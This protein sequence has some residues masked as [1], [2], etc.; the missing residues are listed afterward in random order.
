[1]YKVVK[2]YIRTAFIY[3]Y[4]ILFEESEANSF[5][6][7]SKS[8]QQKTSEKSSRANS[9][10]SFGTR[11]ERI[12]RYFSAHTQYTSTL[13][14]LS[15]TKDTTSTFNFLRSRRNSA[16]T[17]ASISSLASSF[18]SINYA[19]VRQIGLFHHHRRSSLTPASAAQND[20]LE[21]LK[22]VLAVVN[23]SS[24]PKLA[25]SNFSQGD[26]NIVNNILRTLQIKQVYLYKMAMR[27]KSIKEE[28]MLKMHQGGGVSGDEDEMRVG[29][30][31]EW[32]VDVPFSLVVDYE[33][34]SLI[35]TK[36]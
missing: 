24:D 3:N 34:L 2:Y 29:K 1:M 16:S 20:E 25:K 9:V 30:A 10:T 8:K 36:R 4:S 35:R 21:L 7:W 19:D 5:H 28:K 17:T 12:I 11:R 27:C 33:E 18:I 32:L 31:N 6:C 15:N 22:I 23:G 13:N 14:S 26:F